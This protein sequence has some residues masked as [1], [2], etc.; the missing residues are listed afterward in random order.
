MS[1]KLLRSLLCRLLF[2][3]FGFLLLIELVFLH[4]LLNPSGRIHQLLL[5][6]EERVA[7]GAN[8]YIDITNRRPRLEGITARARDS[9]YFV[10]RVYLGFQ[11]SNLR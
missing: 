11:P 5:A 7:V 8:F 6:R 10:F 2:L 3:C 1:L 9:T 4:V